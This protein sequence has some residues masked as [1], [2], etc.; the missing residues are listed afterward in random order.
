MAAAQNL[1]AA[2]LAGMRSIIEVGQSR[3]A[4]RMEELEVVLATW[5]KLAPPPGREEEA[6][7]SSSSSEEKKQ[8][9]PRRQ[10]RAARDVLD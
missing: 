1:T 10:P 9:S 2:D 6:K 4:W 8:Q 5:K 7:S 3:G